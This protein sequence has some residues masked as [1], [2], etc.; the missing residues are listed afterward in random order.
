MCGIYGSPNRSMFE[1]LYEANFSRGSFATSAMIAN[2]NESNTRTFNW[3][4]YNN[5]Q[6]VKEMSGDAYFMG[7]CQAPTSNNRTM[8]PNCTHPFTNGDWVVAHNGVVTNLR[9][10][11]DKYAPYGYSVP[12]D[13]A[14]FPFI[15]AK[16]G[17]STDDEVKVIK[18]ALSYI[19]GTFGLWIFN[20]KTKNLYI[21]RQGVTLFMTNEGDYSGSFSSIKSNGWEEVEEGKLYAIREQKFEHVGDFSNT[22]PFLTM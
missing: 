19:N 7:H 2:T 5:P 11:L 18:Q 14:I 12:V 13:S 8:E 10:A 16:L 21:A 3:E 22:S 1:V 4:G 6:K 15:F 9:E 20:K 17:K